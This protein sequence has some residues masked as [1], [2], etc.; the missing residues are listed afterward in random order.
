MTVVILTPLVTGW[1]IS[2]L[3][4]ELIWAHDRR[5]ASRPE[6]GSD[7]IPQFKQ[8]LPRA[9]AE[10]GEPS[11]R[12]GAALDHM[13]ATLQPDASPSLPPRDARQVQPVD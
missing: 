5:S 10:G 8:H 13:A 9:N 4:S 2:A 6:T 12:R 7:Q 11:P 3:I 1:I